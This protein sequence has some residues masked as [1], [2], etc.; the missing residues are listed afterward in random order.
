MRPGAIRGATRVLG[1]PNGMSDEQCSPLHIHDT[2]ID[3]FPY[4]VSAWIPTPA[5]VELIK[6]GQP[7]F[8]Y[9]N[10]T[11]HPPVMLEVPTE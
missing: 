10:G 7:I 3:G 4:M 8:L 6:R 11:T 1:K 9:I 2:V 5:E